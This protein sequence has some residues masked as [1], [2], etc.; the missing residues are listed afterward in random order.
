MNKTR[1]KFGIFILAFILLA[2]NAISPAMAS[3]KAAFPDASASTVNTILLIPQLMSV[4]FVIFGG[5]IAGKFSKKRLIIIGLI[6][7]AGSGVIGF[8]TESLAVL[9]ASRAAFGVG[10]GLLVPCSLGIASDIFFGTDEYDKIIGMEYSLKSIGSI[11]YTL[12][13]GV[14]CEISWHHTF[15]VYLTGAV[16]LVII[17][18]VIPDIPPEK[19]GREK[20]ADK[21]RNKK[22]QSGPGIPAI[23]IPAILIGFAYSFCIQINGTNFSFV[24]ERGGFGTS[25][26]SG[27]V[28]S[29]VTV[30]AAIGAAAYD[31]ILKKLGDRT[32][33]LGMLC[34]A[35]GF[36]V[37]AA[38]VHVSMLFICAVLLGFGLGMVNPALLMLVGRESK[39]SSTLFFSLIMA[40]MNLGAMV[41]GWVVPSITAAI[42]G[43]DGQ[44]RDAFIVAA[45]GMTICIGLGIL[46]LLRFGKKEKAPGAA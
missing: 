8:F 22:D 15:L 31:W 28:T 29:T 33:L 39:E 21:K 18:F 23:L 36:A 24:I 5:A 37:G 35:A 1:A 19:H 4:P 45:A 7:F 11:F 30:G 43:G 14:L 16:V 17:F 38:A 10:Y 41:Q 9:I 32:F 40:S 12:I 46:M 34:C 42:F 2:T 6:L 20:T 26:V 27:L 3:I 25:W 13:A 44:G